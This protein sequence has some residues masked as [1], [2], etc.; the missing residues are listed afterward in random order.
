MAD[1]CAS[2]PGTVRTQLA[3]AGGVG[4][5]PILQILG[6]CAPIAA[7]DRNG[8][9]RQ[10]ALLLHIPPLGCCTNPFPFCSSDF[11]EI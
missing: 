1:S 8:A 7:S 11:Q 2:I 5:N 3:E 10:T 6:I 9:K 4:G